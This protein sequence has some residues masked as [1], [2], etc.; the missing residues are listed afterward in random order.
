MGRRQQSSDLGTQDNQLDLFASA[1][2]AVGVIEV[3][4]I[5]DC[6][7]CVCGG[8]GHFY[9]GLL[10]QAFCSEECW[11]NKLLTNAR[12]RAVKSTCD[13]GVAVAR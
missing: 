6:C 9:S 4:A 12:S 5:P 8:R 7:L 13:P 11:Q 10:E 1:P 3:E 2:V